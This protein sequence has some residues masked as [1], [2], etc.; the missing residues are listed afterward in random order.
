MVRAPHPPD[1]D[2]SRPRRCWIADRYIGGATGFVEAKGDTPQE[3]LDALARAWP[4]ERLTAGG[5]G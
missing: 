3:A 5:V 2:Q 4:F 1:T